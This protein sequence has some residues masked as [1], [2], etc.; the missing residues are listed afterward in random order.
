MVNINTLA[1]PLCIGYYKEESWADQELRCYS[2]VWKMLN[3]FP[4]S[5][6]LA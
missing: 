6:N 5:Q 3:Q 4:V 1:N 2:A